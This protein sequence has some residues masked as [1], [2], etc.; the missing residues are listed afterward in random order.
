VEELQERDF[1]KRL[2]PEWERFEREARQ[3]FPFIQPDHVALWLEILGKSSRPRVMTAWSDGRLV[4]YAP[5]MEVT[6]STGILDMPTVRFVGNNLVNPGD[7]LFVDVAALEPRTAIVRAI[8]DKLKEGRFFQRWDFGFLPPSSPTSKIACEILQHAGRY[9]D[10]PDATYMSLELPREWD[11]YLIQVGRKVR[12]NY[13]R[14]MRGLQSQGEVRVTAESEPASVARRV[15]QMIQNHDRWARGTA[16]EQAR[17]FGSEPVRRYYVEGARLLA[18]R[19]RYL[20][21]TLQ[22]DDVPIAWITGITDGSRY[23]AMMTSYDESYK[24]HSPGFV[25][26]ME[27]MRLLIDRNLRHVELTTGTSYYKR[28][29][30]GNPVKYPRV[31]GY[32]RL[33]KWALQLERARSFLRFKGLLGSRGEKDSTPSQES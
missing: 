14:S 22:L 30:G 13:A 3:K 33:P 6:D 12:Q 28:A 20:T 31:W 5:F 11:E 17:W 19:G 15:A 25:L 9:T 23:C 2:A 8:L 27:K 7:I 4:G 18:S 16:R 1:A 21:F 10:E 26:F 24:A 32:P 29:L